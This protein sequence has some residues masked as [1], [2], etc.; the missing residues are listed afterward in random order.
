MRSSLQSNIKLTGIKS[1]A[2]LNL[3]VSGLEQR[4]LSILVRLAL[5][6]YQPMPTFKMPEQLSIVHIPIQPHPD[7]ES[8]EVIVKS[9]SGETLYHESFYRDCGGRIIRTIEIREKRPKPLEIPWVQMLVMWA[10]VLVLGMGA[11]LAL[12]VVS[13]IINRSF[14]V[15]HAQ[16]EVANRA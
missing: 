1:E 8:Q 11:Y 16:S 5:C 9:S 7:I 4:L 6:P 15:K 3:P 13:Q 2:I 14:E 12:S 10:Y